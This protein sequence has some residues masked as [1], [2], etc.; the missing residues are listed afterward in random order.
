MQIDGCLYD[1]SND[2]CG[3][4]LRQPLSL[5]D[6]LI[7]IFAVDILSNDVNMSLAS[8]G[9]LVF[10]NLRVRYYLHDLAFVV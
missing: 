1:L 4:I 6:V 2:K 10:N 7:Q 5:P 3:N 8:N 9:F